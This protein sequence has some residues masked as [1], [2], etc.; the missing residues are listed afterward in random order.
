M[1]DN[2][3]MT[4]PIIP[5]MKT[6]NGTALDDWLTVAVKILPAIT[7]WSVTLQGL[8]FCLFRNRRN[9]QNGRELP[10]YD[11]GVFQIK[12]VPSICFLNRQ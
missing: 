8:C 1:P 2:C 11:T 9:Q 5:F 6:L 10:K 3:H 7:P 4:N 12:K